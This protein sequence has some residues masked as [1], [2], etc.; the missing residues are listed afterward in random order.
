M[1][2]LTSVIL[3]ICLLASMFGCV[4]NSKNLTSQSE[5]IEM[6]QKNEKNFTDAS[7]SGDFS[8]LEAIAGV[9]EVVAHDEY[10][11]IQCGGSGLGS[12]THYFGILYSADEN[13]ISLDVAEPY[14]SV[15]QEGM[16]YRYT[17]DNGDNFCYIEP[18][19]NHF[20]YYEAHF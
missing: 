17:Q 4:G 1:K 9:Q 6:Y 16:G 8:E 2:K 11:D 12:S 18:L 19:G 14:D 20:Y 5:I 7:L 15:M 13:F 3:T 10:I